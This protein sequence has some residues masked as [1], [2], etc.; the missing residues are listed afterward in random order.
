[1]TT[2]NLKLYVTKHRDITY[3]KFNVVPNCQIF[4]MTDFYFRKY[5]YWIYNKGDTRSTYP[6]GSPL[7][8]TTKPWTLRANCTKLTTVREE[9]M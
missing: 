6:P 2:K 3:I 5:I 9:T 8:T 1:M 7:L 4:C